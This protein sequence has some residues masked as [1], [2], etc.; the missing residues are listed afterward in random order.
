MKVFINRVKLNHWTSS[1]IE[2]R[3]IRRA[4]PA[5]AWFLRDRADLSQ[6]NTENRLETHSNLRCFYVECA[7]SKLDLQ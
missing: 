7:M 6:E 5:L 4:E 3:L 2:R 1:E